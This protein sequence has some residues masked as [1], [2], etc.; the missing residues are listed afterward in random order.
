MSTKNYHNTVRSLMEI[1]KTSQEQLIVNICMEL[2]CPEKCEGMTEKFIDKNIKMKK[3]KD[4][5]AP[6]NVCTG[7]QFFCN[8][9]RIIL[10]KENPAITFKEL[11][12]SLSKAWNSIDPET[13]KKYILMS[14]KDKERYTLEYEKYKSSLFSSTVSL[15]DA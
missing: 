9:T 4:K 10:K 12:Q 5:N 15:S 6:K 7:Y 11:M 2:G 3:F 13:K 1:F 8:E 14:E